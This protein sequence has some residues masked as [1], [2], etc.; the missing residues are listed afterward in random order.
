MSEI[1]VWV[2]GAV[3]WLG[4]VLGWGVVTGL[5][6]RRWGYD[7]SDDRL[8]QTSGLVVGATWPFI[9]LGFVA[10]LGVVVPVLILARLV[11][12]KVKM[13]KEEDSD[14]R[15]ILIPDAV[16]SL[17][18][19]RPESERVKFI[20]KSYQEEISRLQK[21]IDKLDAALGECHQENDRQH[22]KNT[23]QAKEILRLRE[24]ILSCSLDPEECNALWGIGRRCHLKANHEAGHASFPGR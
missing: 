1:P 2:L 8:Q 4:Y 7:L 16:T 13:E 6:A 15:K 3:G 10:F 18:S 19:L 17:D 12:G 20:V 11:A 22:S 9:V 23:A 14:P 24:I 21:H 5:L